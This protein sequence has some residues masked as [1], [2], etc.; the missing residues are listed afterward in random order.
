MA[1]GNKKVER[2]EEKPEGFIGSK[3]RKDKSKG[4][5]SQVLNVQRS[6]SEVEVKV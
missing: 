3:R 4:R 1:E 6:N 5:N 2:T